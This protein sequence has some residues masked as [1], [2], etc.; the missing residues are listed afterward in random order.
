[1]ILQNKIMICGPQNLD[2]C[3]HTIHDENAEPLTYD[4]INANDMMMIIII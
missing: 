1:M 4:H 3:D 2:L